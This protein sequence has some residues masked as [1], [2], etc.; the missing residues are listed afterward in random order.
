MK[1]YEHILPNLLPKQMKNKKIAL[2]F[3]S[4]N[5][6]HN[7]HLAIA[8]HVL[9]TGYSDELWF[10]VSPRSPFKNRPDL[11]SEQHRLAM[12]NLAIGGEENIKAC[13]IEFSMP[14]PSYTIDTLLKLHDDFPQHTF[15]LVMGADNLE[16]FNQWKQW[17][18]IIKD[19]LIYVYPR[20]NS[21]DNLMTDPNIII[22]NEAPLLDISSSMI[23]EKIKKG[24][25]ADNYLNP[26]VAQYTLKQRLYK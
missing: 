17:K 8:N 21:Q 23:R 16:Y 10:V 3:G 4:F 13:D 9:K 14:R 19:H 12:L 1:K 6:I 5:P 18:K 26:E 24:I 25:S 7:G 20:N 22:M 11:A 2:Y 15:S